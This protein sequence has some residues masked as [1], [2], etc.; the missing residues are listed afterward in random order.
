MRTVVISHITIKTVIIE[1][2]ELQDDQAT[3]DG[4]AGHVERMDFE[5]VV[6]SSTKHYAL[7]SKENNATN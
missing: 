5:K 6:G 2:P 3:F 4:A 1:V 7:L